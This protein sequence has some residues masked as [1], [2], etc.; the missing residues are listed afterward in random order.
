MQNT[1]EHL[2]IFGRRECSDKYLDDHLFNLS[3][4]HT[5]NMIQLRTI[6]NRHMLRESST[7][8]PSSIF[9]LR[10]PSTI[11]RNIR[12]TRI[13]DLIRVVTLNAAVMTSGSLTYL[14]GCGI[15]S[16]DSNQVCYRKHRMVLTE[17]AGDAE[18]VLWDGREFGHW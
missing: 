6:G 7:S 12:V 16:N 14:M 3:P 11:H 17:A 13:N 9:A 2:G 8:N 10:N 18:L 1:I 15:A 5:D 4:F